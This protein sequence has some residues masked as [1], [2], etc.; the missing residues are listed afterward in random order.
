[1]SRTR[2]K[3]LLALLVVPLFLWWLFSSPSKGPGDGIIWSIAVTRSHGTW[4]NVAATQIYVATTGAIYVPSWWG[5]S[6]KRKAVGRPDTPL[7]TLAADPDGNIAAGTAAGEVYVSSDLGDHWSGNKVSN[8]PISSIVILGSGKYLV[9]TFGDGI[10][11]LENGLSAKRVQG[12]ELDLNVW[13]LAS[14]HNHRHLMA[15]AV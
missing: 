5:I 3:L 15:I 12:G 13:C 4:K 7:I 2:L 14:D 10:F 6:W 9:A 11:Q 1:M 8:F